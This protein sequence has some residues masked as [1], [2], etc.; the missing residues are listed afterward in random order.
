[1]E[2]WEGAKEEEMVVFEETGKEGMREE[3]QRQEMACTLHAAEVA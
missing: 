1:M 3:I 2:N